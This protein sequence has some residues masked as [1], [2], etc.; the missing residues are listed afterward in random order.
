[1]ATTGEMDNVVT[2]NLPTKQTNFVYS[3]YRD[4][5]NSCNNQANKIDKLPNY[6]DLNS[7]QRN[8]TAGSDL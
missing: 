6:I 5:L 2:P 7:D 8:N 3:N 4:V 1:M